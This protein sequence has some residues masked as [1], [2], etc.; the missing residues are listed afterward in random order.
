MRSDYFFEN[1]HVCFGGIVRPGIV[2]L[3]FGVELEPMGY[4]FL[5]FVDHLAKLKQSCE[6]SLSREKNTLSSG[7]D[8]G[9]FFVSLSIFLRSFV[10]FWR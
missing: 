1:W 5:D 2:L 6:K 8:I 10:S 7:S 9:L 3:R 4:N